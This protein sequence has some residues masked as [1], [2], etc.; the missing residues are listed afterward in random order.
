M[1]IVG[2]AGVGKDLLRELFVEKGF[3]SSISYTTR[4]KREH[5]IADKDY[6][7]VTNEKFESDINNQTFYEYVKFNEWFYGTSKHSFKNDN[8]FIM[9]PTGI[10]KLTKEDRK[11]SLIIFLDLDDETIRERINE[12]NDMIGDSL[13]RRFLSD[14]KDFENFTDYDIRITN[15]DFNKMFYD[16]KVK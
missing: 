10:S 15:E 7:F 9:T 11:E 1:I 3:K 12:R 8:V 4:P 6:Y 13:N 16:K 5:E 14:K 2:K